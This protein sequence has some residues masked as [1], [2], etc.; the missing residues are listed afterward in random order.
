MA[1]LFLGTAPLLLA[2]LVAVV[3]SLVITNKKNLRD[4][5]VWWAT[6][7]VSAWAPFTLLLFLYMAFLL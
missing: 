3:V 4:R 2:L 1:V 6:C 7:W 5:P